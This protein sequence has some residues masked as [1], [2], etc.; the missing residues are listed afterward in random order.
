MTVQQ[1]V[2]ILVCIFPVTV[3][4][5]TLFDQPPIEIGN[6]HG[7]P[8]GVASA[9]ADKIVN[10]SQ[11]YDNF[12]LS[13]PIE[14]NSIQWTGSYLRGFLADTPRV[15]T[16][17]RVQ[18]FSDSSNRPDVAS[19][20]VADFVLDSGT[21]GL[22][23]GSDVQTSVVAD[24]LSEGG[25]NIVNYQADLAAP[26]MLDPGTYWMSIQA[27]QTLSGDLDFDH[28]EWLWAL[29]TS[30]D[31]FLYS[32]DELFDPV[33]S[34]PGI[35]TNVYDAAFSL[36][37][38]M[39]VLTGDF[40]LNG[41]LE[42]ADIDLLSAAVRANSTDTLYDLNQD[43]VVSPDDHQ[44]WVD[45]LKGVLVGDADMNLEVAFIDFLGLANN[46]GQNGGWAEGNFDTNESVDFIDF[47]ALANNFGSFAPESA[48]A[49]VPEP[50]GF[51][52]AFVGG[53]SITVLRRRRG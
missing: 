7:G 16:A 5:A 40:D 14:V 29:S 50:V 32:Y 43:G 24:Q 38:E 10:E 15:N 34:Q 36:F 39:L 27:L 45:E 33:G 35:A 12:V 26:L 3:R 46:F 37:G 49:A 1:L 18:V 31:T 47:L 21:A 30:G 53:L 9:K 48:A 13:Q 41:V 28:P 11:A 44:F 6:P 19:P 22:D 51:A 20:L 8:T 2:V 17:F 4:A 52:T 42:A 23:D 25:G